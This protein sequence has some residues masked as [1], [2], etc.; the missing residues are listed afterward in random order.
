VFGD[1]RRYD[2]FHVATAAILGVRAGRRRATAGRRSR[3]TT[4]RGS[5]RCSARGRSRRSRTAE[6]TGRW[7]SPPARYRGSTA[8]T[9]RSPRGPIA[10][11]CSRSLSGSPASSSADGSLATWP[12]ACTSRAAPRLR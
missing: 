5:A 2:A 9:R 11:W 1:D 3:S 6:R 4:R 7:R 10:S 12:R 8:R